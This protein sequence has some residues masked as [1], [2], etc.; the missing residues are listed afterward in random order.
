MAAT[1]YNIGILSDD[2]LKQEFINESKKVL[3]SI[4]KKYNC[5]VEFYQTEIAGKAKEVK[6]NI[7]SAA[8]KV[9]QKESSKHIGLSFCGE[10]EL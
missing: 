2:K 10:I 1:K 9:K 7:I 3:E 5:T 6:K 8:G 4:A